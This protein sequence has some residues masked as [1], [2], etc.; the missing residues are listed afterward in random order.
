MW[1]CNK[2]GQTDE[3]ILKINKIN[4]T[5][6]AKGK[7]RLSFYTK[8]VAIELQGCPRDSKTNM[9]QL[10]F[11]TKMGKKNIKKITASLTR[12]SL[13]RLSKFPQTLTETQKGVT[14]K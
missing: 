4:D 14:T 2:W 5:Y 3:A 12:N 7:K 11:D 9:S 13:A 8:A 10:N 6:L 1:S